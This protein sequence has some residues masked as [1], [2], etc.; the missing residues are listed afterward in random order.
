MINYKCIRLVIIY[1]EILID[2]NV[3]GSCYLSVEK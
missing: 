3:Y 1:K 2:F